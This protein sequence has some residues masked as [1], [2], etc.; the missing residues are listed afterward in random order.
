MKFITFKDE[1]SSDDIIHYVNVNAINEISVHQD[2]KSIII[3]TND[4]KYLVKVTLY[5]IEYVT[6]TIFESAP[7]H[8]TT[9][10]P[11]K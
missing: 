7:E 10:L 8:I 2:I 9:I 3:K 4:G 6:N 11:I 5:P 1:L